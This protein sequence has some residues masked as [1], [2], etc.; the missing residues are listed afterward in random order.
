MKGTSSGLYTKI[1]KL[2]LE[3]G[4]NIG[5]AGSSWTAIFL[6]IHASCPLL[7]G[8]ISP[9]KCMFLLKECFKPDFNSIEMYKF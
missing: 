6:Y 4:T 3:P 2:H 1:G 5:L 7:G 9:G 8:D